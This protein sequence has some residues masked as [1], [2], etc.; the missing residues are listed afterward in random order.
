MACFFFLSHFACMSLL[1]RSSSIVFSLVVTLLFSG[2]KDPGKPLSKQETPE[3]DPPTAAR[4][5]DISE[6]TPEE[7]L[8][9]LAIQGLANREGTRVF[10]QTRD[11][12]RWNQ[13]EYERDNEEKGG[14]L[15]SQADIDRLRPLYHNTTDYWMAYFSRT[16][17]ATFTPATLAELFKEFAPDIQGAI[18][19]EK[20]NDDLAIAGTMA[21]LENAIPMTPSIHE[22]LEKE[23]GAVIPVV[24]DVR[25][26]YPGYDPKSERRIEAHRWAIKNLLPRCEK[27]AALSRDKTYGRNE[28]DT[29]IDADLA[30]RNRWMIFDLTFMSE[31]T[32]T[33]GKRDKPHPEWGFT[34]PDTPLLIEILQSLDQPYPPIYGWG[35]PY[36]SAL[37]R[38]LAINGGVKIC[39][40]NGN[41]SFFQ[42]LPP[43]DG[44]FAQI[45]P[46]AENVELENKVYVAFATNE[47]DTLKYL[48]GLVNGGTWL[49]SERGSIPINWAMDPLL[50]E[51][52]PGLVRHYYDTA[53]PNDYFFSAPSGWGYLAPFMLPA[54]QI[55]VYGELV[56]N[57]GRMADLRYIDVWWMAG[58][59]ERGLFFPY[60][61]AMGMRGLTQ[62]SDR[63]EVEFAPDGT[64]IIHSNF[65]Y[66]RFR[67]E[68]L[69]AKLRT[70]AEEMKG[71][72][73]IYIYGGYPHWFAEI[74]K[75]LPAE[76]FKVVKK[77]EFFEAARLARPLVEGR[78]FRAKPDEISEAP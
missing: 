55:P 58:L 13:I 26:L 66:P 1:L 46:H 34:P 29:L 37:I 36:E 20:L 68:V 65:Y 44:D 24:F 60:L 5:V 56:K 3:P 41:A 62:W 61:Q 67:P 73:F 72:W 18:L 47:G 2:C 4:V 70:V 52:F 54:D 42:S 77:D 15:W 40:G 38:R 59:R 12:I 78:V 45:K 33:G 17:V 16:G 8:A 53:T 11:A 31:E 35:R 25:S 22:A 76:Q 27:S 63:Q 6:M 64:P 28:H 32:R 71:P 14:R 49:Q 69:A 74:A 75:R 30:I 50:Y 48:T 9:V 21:G 10:L 43:G 51:K 7:R 19:Y 39:T 23:I 57:G